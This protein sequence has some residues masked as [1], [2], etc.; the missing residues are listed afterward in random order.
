MSAHDEGTVARWR[1]EPRHAALELDDPIF[2]E[3]ATPL[4]KDLTLASVVAI[5]LW[6]AAAAVFG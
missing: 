6:V 2:P 1:L 4:W 3:Q 5:L